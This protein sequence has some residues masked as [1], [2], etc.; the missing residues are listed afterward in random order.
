MTYVLLAYPL[1]VYK[2]CYQYVMK[3]VLVI[4]LHLM[5][6]NLYAWFS[7]VLLTNTVTTQLYFNPVP[8]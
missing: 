4:L 7:D 1:Q 2:H 8:P 5:L 3:I 6:R